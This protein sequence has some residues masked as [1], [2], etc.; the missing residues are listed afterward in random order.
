[1]GTPQTDPTFSFESMERLQMIN[2]LYANT[3]IS[4]STNDC[5]DKQRNWPFSWRTFDMESTGVKNLINDVT[6]TGTLIVRV[7]SYTC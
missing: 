3:Y 5:K 2:R 1:M 7:M 4:V 6:L